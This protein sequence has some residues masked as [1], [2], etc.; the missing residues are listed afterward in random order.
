MEVYSETR[1]KS[2]EKPGRYGLSNNW[3]ESPVFAAGTQM[4][5]AILFFARKGRFVGSRRRKPPDAGAISSLSSSSSSPEGAAVAWP[6]HYDR[7]FGAGKKGERGGESPRHPGASATRLPTAAPAG[8]PRLNHAQSQ[9]VDFSHLGR[10]PGPGI[11][12]SRLNFVQLDHF[13]ASC[14]IS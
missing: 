3:G 1:A 11:R 8:L 4:T 5:V 7:P 13:G 6:P 2:S 10:H 14:V 9:R 12:D